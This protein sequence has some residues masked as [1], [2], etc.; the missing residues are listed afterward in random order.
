MQFLA[1]HQVHCLKQTRFY[2]CNKRSNGIFS[3]NQFFG[4]V[5]AQLTLAQ[6]KIYIHLYSPKNGS[7][8]INENKQK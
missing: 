8:N 7:I 6:K 4:R 5:R 2:N 1:D 3:L